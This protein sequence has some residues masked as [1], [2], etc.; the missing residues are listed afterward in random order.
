MHPAHP[1][2][3][4]SGARTAS[5]LLAFPSISQPPVRCVLTPPPPPQTPPSASKPQSPAPMPTA[6]IYSRAPTSPTFPWCIL[7]QACVEP[8]TLISCQLCN[9]HQKSCQIWR[10]YATG[11]K[12]VA[13]YG[14][15]LALSTGPGA[16]TGGR[17]CLKGQ[18]T[19]G[20]HPPY[21]ASLC[22]G[23]RWV[24]TAILCGTCNPLPPILASVVPCQV[25]PGTTHSCASPPGQDRKHAPEIRGVGG[26]G[27]REP[28]DPDGCLADVQG[29]DCRTPCRAIFRP[30]SCCVHPP[31]PPR[32][33][34]GRTLD[35]PPIP[36][37]PASINSPHAQ[38]QRR[39]T[40][41]PP[42]LPGLTRSQLSAWASCRRSHVLTLQRAVAY[43]R[44]S[45]RS[46]CQKNF[47]REA[48]TGLT[49]TGERTI[50][51]QSASL[52]RERNGHTETKLKKHTTR[53]LAVG[54]GITYTSLTQPQLH[55]RRERAT[56]T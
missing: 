44:L 7:Q 54:D 37:S 51:G 28:P 45:R 10:N 4:T 31:C 17:G 19:P 23:P 30:S 27:A 3:C 33:W 26:L 32:A 15:A 21:L 46:A 56:P 36:P 16:I 1:K 22:V 41:A 49:H 48:V 24:L 38:H 52:V 50:Q 35:P 25:T 2:Q 40:L 20:P 5:F 53:T 14:T 12:K 43:R 13:K 11:I 34:R 42:L 9:R 8:G 39:Q 6:N 55:T 47:S 29:A 18:V